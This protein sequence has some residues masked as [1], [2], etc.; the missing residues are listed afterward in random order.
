MNLGIYLSP[1]A[2]Y[3]LDD[4]RFGLVGDIIEDDAEKI[5]RSITSCCAWGSSRFPPIRYWAD[6]IPIFWLFRSLCDFLP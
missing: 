3:C 4:V 1:L 6:S 5:A 2:V